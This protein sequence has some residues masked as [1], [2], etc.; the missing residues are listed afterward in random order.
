MESASPWSTRCPAAYADEIEALLVHDSFVLIQ[1]PSYSLMPFTT[2]RVA[3][4]Y[5]AQLSLIDQSNTDLVKKLADSMLK[6]AINKDTNLFYEST[7]FDGTPGGSSMD[8][9]WGADVYLSSLLKSY[10]ATKDKEYLEQVK[11]TIQA[12]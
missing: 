1:A 4:N 8:I 6:Y 3:L 11:K 7:Y 12:Y 9:P 5:V 2:N 10:E